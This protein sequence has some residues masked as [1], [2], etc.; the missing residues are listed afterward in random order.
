MLAMSR[1]VE[2]TSQ[3]YFVA[4]LVHVFNRPEK[5]KMLGISKYVPFVEP[6][7]GVPCPVDSL[8]FT[9]H[10]HVMRCARNNRLDKVPA[11]TS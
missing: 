7:L 11:A 2:K 10:C 1:L 9:R 4:I 8:S 3:P 5:M 6:L